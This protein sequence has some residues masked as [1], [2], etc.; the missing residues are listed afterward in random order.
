[1]KKIYISILAVAAM[2]LA[3]CNKEQHIDE[4]VQDVV[5]NNYPALKAVIDPETKMDLNGTQLSFE[6][7]DCISVFNGIVTETVTDETTGEETVTE[8]G[9]R[10]GHTLY[11][12]T[13]VEDGVATFE[14]MESNAYK[15]APEVDIVATYPNRGVSTS[16]FEPEG[17]AYGEGTVKIRMVA[18]ADK[19]FD[20]RTL[21]V[22][23]SATKGQMLQFKHTAGLLELNLKGTQ[24][25]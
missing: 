10:H 21:P 17:E 19:A 3:A 25:I 23:A 15:P 12:C 4:P 1:M 16:A 22:I 2:T 20:A 11:E 13:A 6:V 9:D 18:T 14:W 5:E 7:G 24:T 8:T